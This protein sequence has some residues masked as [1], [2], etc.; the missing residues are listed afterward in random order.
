MIKIEDIR[1]M[2]NQFKVGQKYKSGVIIFV[3]EYFITV[4]GDKGIKITYYYVDM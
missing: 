4:K 3:G 2:K 1:A